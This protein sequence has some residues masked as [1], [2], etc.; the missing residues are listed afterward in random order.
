MG[1]GLDPASRRRMV[2]EGRRVESRE[3]RAAPD[4]PAGKKPG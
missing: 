2:C 3:D 4:G 1:I